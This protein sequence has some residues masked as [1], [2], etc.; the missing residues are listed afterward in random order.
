MIADVGISMGK[1]GS[2]AAIE[3]S[4]VVITNDNLTKIKLSKRIA[5]KVITIV[6]ENIYF[7]IGVKVL[8]LILSALGYAEMWLAIFADVGVSFLAI[9]NSLR[10]NLIKK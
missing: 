9:L 2:D 5:K 7:A 8:V 1:V 3:A 4:D 6:N 10:V